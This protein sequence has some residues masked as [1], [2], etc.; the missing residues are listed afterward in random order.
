DPVVGRDK[1]IDEVIDVL[2]KRRTNNPC[3]VG[4]PGVGKTAVVEGVA[5]TLLRLHGPMSQRI[6]IELDMATLVAGTQ[7]RGSFSERL[8]AIKDEVKRAEGRI[9]VFI[10]E[11]H[12][13]MGAGSTGEGPQDAAN[14]LKSAMARGDFPCIGATTHE[15]FRKFISADPALERRFTAL[16]VR[17]PTVAETVEILHGIISRY[18][19]H[20]QLAYTPA[21]LEA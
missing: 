13:L 17:E 15:E 14:E 20:H 8:N 10:D 21:A 9:V 18:E 4:E 19:A 5:Q 16:T 12:T 11:L 2:G 3:L 7:L 6:V 1:E